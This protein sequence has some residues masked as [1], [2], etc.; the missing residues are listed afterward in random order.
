MSERTPEAALAEEF[1]DLAEQC[2]EELEAMDDGEYDDYTKG[3]LDA[4][5]SAAVAARMCQFA[6]EHA[7]A[8]DARE[9]RE[10]GDRD[11]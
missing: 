9:E 10:G 5:R 7:A 11:E 1:A 3:R 2:Y 8:D 6:R 4:F